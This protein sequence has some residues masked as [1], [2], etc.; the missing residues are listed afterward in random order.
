MRSLSVDLD[1]LRGALPRNL[2]ELDELT[3]AQVNEL[4]GYYHNTLKEELNR[5]APSE[6]ESRRRLCWQIIGVMK[7]EQT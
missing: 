4:C 7:V 2:A 5:L 1:V 3:N 6:T